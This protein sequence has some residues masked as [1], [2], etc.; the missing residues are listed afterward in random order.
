MQDNQ[1]K[2]VASILSGVLSVGINHPLDTLRIR[3]HLL[4]HPTTNTVSNHVN[5]LSV[6]NMRT[7]MNGIVFNISSTCFKNVISYP[8]REQIGNI[9]KN[10]YHNSLSDNQLSIN[11]SSA[12]IT[13]II[14]AGVNTPV[15]IVKI[16]LQHDHT[17]TH[18]LKDVMREIY[19]S[20][21]AKSFYKGG[22]V[23]LFR[24]VSWNV[25]YFPLFDIVTNKLDNSTNISNVSNR[26]ISSIVCSM[27]ATTLAYPFDGLRIFRQRLNNNVQY[28]FWVGIKKSFELSKP[29]IKSY[30]YAMIRVPL[31]T[32][33]THIGYIYIT[34]YLKS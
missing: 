15:N 22:I 7:L 2:F 27:A 33:I 24:D 28:D 17:K 12:T 16:Q 23:T 8:I 10:H 32:C 13:G 30:T 25:V 34:K 3:Y 29:N 20:N 19:N 6:G 21:G 26:I 5:K 1:A 9:I 4:N 14:M 18:K 11:I 31:A